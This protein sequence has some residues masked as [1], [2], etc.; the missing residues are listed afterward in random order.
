MSGPGHHHEGTAPRPLGAGGTNLPGSLPSRARASQSRPRAAGFAVRRLGRPAVTRRRLASW[1]CGSRYPTQWCGGSLPPSYGQACRPPSYGQAC[2]PPSYG[3]ACRPPSYGQAC[4]LVTCGHGSLRRTHC[5]TQDETRRRPRS[6]GDRDA[7]SQEPGCSPRRRKPG[8]SE[9]H[10]SQGTCCCDT[11]RSRKP[12]W[13]RAV[14]HRRPGVPS[15][16]SRHPRAPTDHGGS[17]PRSYSSAC[18][19]RP[20]NGRCAPPGS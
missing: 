5:G 1:R 8:W 7:R 6:A 11:R 12:G 10:C 13:S 15:R 19:Q 20:A 18:H 16:G 14:R 9:A 17:G 2:R 3:Q 4:R